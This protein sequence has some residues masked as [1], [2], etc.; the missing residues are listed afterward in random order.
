MGTRGLI[1][2]RF[3]RRYYVRFNRLDSYFE[4]LGASIVAGIPADPDEYRA[5]L[6]KERAKYAALEKKLEDEVYELRDGVDSIPRGFY[7]FL[8]FPSELPLLDNLDAEYTY[9]TNLDQEILT[10]NQGIHWKLANIPRKDN[11]WLRSIA[12]S[13][14]VGKPTICL[15]TCPEEYVASPALPAPSDNM[16]MDINFRLVVPAASVEGGR[17]MLLA[18]LLARVFEAYQRQITQFALEWA[19]D[20]FPFRELVFALVSIASGKARLN[21]CVPGPEVMELCADRVWAETADKEPPVPFGTMFHRPGEPPGASPSETIYW[22]DDVLVCLTRMPDGESVTR[23]VD[24]GWDEGFGHFQ[25]VI[26]SV[27]D[28]VFAEV[29]P[30]DDDLPF[31]KVTARMPLSPIRK[32]HCVS[33]H[34]RERPAAKPN[35]N[36]RFATEDRVMRS[37]PSWDMR[38][39]DRLFV[40]CAALVNFFNVAGNRRAATASPGRLPPELYEQIIGHLDHETWNSCLD[41]SQQIRQICLRKFRLDHQM[42]LVAPPPQLPQGKHKKRPISFHAQNVQS[43]RIVQLT[44]CPTY[45]NPLWENRYNWVPVI[46]DNLKLAMQNALIEFKIS[47]DSEERTHNEPDSQISS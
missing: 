21:P 32:H 36:Q 19:A 25:I 24:Y 47:A 2:V 30:G 3:N 37:F 38:I 28:V 27:F 20:S 10:M 39:F 34:P 8:E 12:D 16:E 11:L 46:G 5:W 35:M 9:I 15:E 33:S 42:R 22:L 7:N 45:L 23:A 44:P 18:Y 43:G 13:V 40:G 1:I 6:D 26:L 14:Y 17:S 29:S 41:V 31:V 4:G